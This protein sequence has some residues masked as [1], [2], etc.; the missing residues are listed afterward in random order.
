MATTSSVHKLLGPPELYTSQSNKSINSAGAKP[1]FMDLMAENF[2]NAGNSYSPPPFYPP[3]YSYGVG[4]SLRGYTE[5]G[6]ETY[7]STGNPL[8]DFFFHIVPDTPSESVTAR[9]ESAWAYDPLK[10][11]K[12]ICNLRG[13]RGTGKSDREGF[14]A[15][16]LWLHK[17]HPKTLAGNVKAIADFGYFKDLPEILY[18]LQE[19]VDIRKK[20]KEE[21]LMKKNP[22]TR[23]VGMFDRKRN[24]FY[25]VK[26]TVRTVYKKNKLPKWK[27]K[28]R[29]R[30][31]AASRRRD[32]AEKEKARGWRTAK[33][34]E[35]WKKAIDMYNRDADYRFLH[36][37]IS[38][39]F[40]KCLIS[41]VKLLNAGELKKISWSAKWCP[42]LGS[43]FDKSTL[44]CESIARRIY[45]RD[46]YPE[47]AAIEEA[48]YAYRIRDRLRK[49]FLAPL[50]RALELPEVYMGCNKWDSLPY[51]LV[52]SVAMKNY[53]YTFA[54]RD[55]TRFNN[56]L[57]SVKRGKSSIAAGALLPHLILDSLKGKKGQDVAELQWKR[58]VDDL[59]KIG[60]LNDC[61]AISDVSASM[62]GTPMDVA[63]A[64]GLLVSD[65]CQEPWKGKLI[66]FSTDPKLHKIEGEKLK[67][68]MQS[69]KGMDAG[70]S[71]DFQKVFD[72]ILQV[73]VNGRLR[74]DQMIKRLFVFSDMEFNEAS[75]KASYWNN[76]RNNY[77]NNMP[78]QASN[79]WETDYRVIQK[80]F[81]AKGYRVPEI[82]FWNLRDSSATPVLGEQKGVALVSGFSKNMLKLFLESGSV[83]ELQPIAL[84]E[85]A[86]SG[87]EYSNLVVLD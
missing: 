23:T 36:D 26:H 35:K 49:E 62:N 5:N 44:L 85:K 80:K 13:V 79:D 70:L 40:A 38:A 1:A 14:Y 74:E 18:R 72:L 56:Y 31:V 52:P 2:N 55:A 59:S 51:N 66:T 45:T 4:S 27:R 60:T 82:V 25:Y 8:L 68:K 15:A 50:R 63:I 9:L 20:L 46:S 76:H 73:A 16:A 65:L 48:H 43:S 87:A 22:R 29:E 41:D 54:R 32:A 42:S 30:R 53:K 78:R 58:M 57:E 6:S 24:K 71:T 77:Y 67:S 69:I 61:L 64:L 12:L 39:L 11:L 81:R 28:Q 34:M 47:Y 84:M 10:A 86:I 83:K 19:G 37:A 17:H 33:T 7:V 21:W 3:S 75:R